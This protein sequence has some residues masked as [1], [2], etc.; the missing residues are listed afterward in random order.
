MTEDEAI[1]LLS[2]CRK[3]RNKILYAYI[4]TLLHTGMRASE[5]AGL[6][7]NQID[8]GK[9]TI[10]LQ[11]TKNSDSR[12]VPLT[13]EL[14]KELSNLSTLTEAEG[15]KLVF[16]KED[17]LQA[18]RVKARPGIRF[19]EAFNHA[20]QRAGLPDIHMH[21]LSTYGSKPFDNGRS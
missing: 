11:A 18:P 3:S 17:Q 4:L 14:A 16:L 15:N 10:F 21:D 1:R 8:C 5:A 6:R 9:R 19:R 20:K 2:A 13:K 12:W 7:W